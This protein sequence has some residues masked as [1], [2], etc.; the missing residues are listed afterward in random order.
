MHQRKDPERKWSELKAKVIAVVPMVSLGR[1]LFS[2]E[3]DT[4]KT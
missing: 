4:N 1:E 2:Q 3:T